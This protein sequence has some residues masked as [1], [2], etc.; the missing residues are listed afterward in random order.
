MGYMIKYTGI[1]ILL[2]F[3]TACS[4]KSTNDTDILSKNETKSELISDKSNSFGFGLFKKLN[5]KKDDHRNV[6][7]SPLSTAMVLGMAYN[8]VEG[9]TK[10]KFSEVLGWE[11][12]SVI[13][14]NG[15]NNRLID[16]LQQ[17]SENIRMNIS[18]SVW[19]DEQLNIKE[20]F[21]K[22]NR[23]SFQT[24]TSSIDTEDRSAANIINHWVAES[25]DGNI[26]GVMDNISSQD[27]LYILNATYFKGNWKN[28]FNESKTKKSQF[29]LEDKS[30]T[31]VSMMWQKADLNYYDGED[32]QFVELPYE[33][34]SY[35]MYI[36]LPDSNKKVD[37]TIENLSYSSWHFYKEKLSKKRNINFGMPRFHCEH[38]I[39]MKDLLG[40]MG[41]GKLFVRDKTDLSGITER[42]VA[43]SEMMHKAAVDVDEKG[44]EASAA[45]SLAISFTTLVEDNPFNLIVNRPFVFAIEEKKSNTLLFIGKVTNP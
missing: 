4:K 19:F 8:G 15:Y 10:Q 18:N 5:T 26:S 39:K 16:H 35:C 37:E 3:V 45:T 23:E 9:E 20:S 28:D 33:D 22:R 21:L 32:F 43:I 36:L 2:F 34:E 14:L 31:P 13:E 24:Y 11:D 6:V 44:T 30:S 41:L 1:L 38:A 25:T 17:Q 29:F 12:V 7:I 40:G 27:M 42:K